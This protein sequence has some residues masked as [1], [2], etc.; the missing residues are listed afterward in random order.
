MMLWVWIIV[1]VVSLFA[2][3]K[4]A[5]Y[6]IDYSK[7]I[8]AALKVPDFIVGVTLIAMGTSLPE[9]ITGIIA[10]SKNQTEI[11]V[12]NAFG[13]NIANILL[14][15]GI[16]AVL[17]SRILK[18]DWEITKIDMPLL[19]IATVIAVFIALDGQITF[20]EGIFAILAYVIYMLYALKV[21]NKD[22][23]QRVKGE[24]KPYYFLII[25]A[26]SIVIYLSAKYTVT[27][28]INIS[29]ILN[30]ATSLI[31]ATAVAIGTSLPEL[32]VSLNALKKG[33][34]GMAVGNVLGSSIFNSLMI[35]G[36]PSLI[37]TIQVDTLTITVTIPFVIAATLIYLF[38]AWDKEVSEYEGAMMIIVYLLFLLK[39][40]G[41]I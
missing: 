22:K 2:L 5:D 39:I 25:I 6:F 11:V 21:A 20:L 17:A 13:S 38:V 24:L 35:L 32:F 40:F 27:S 18:T 36:I 7:K 31:A 33:N 12:A 28:I 34:Y 30:I 26:A 16:T 8:A 41:A 14:V 29:Q 23:S 10:T 15:L 3:S 19:A 4:S 1:F 37:K 9:L